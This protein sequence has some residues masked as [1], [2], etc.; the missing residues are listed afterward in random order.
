MLKLLA[1][2]AAGA[3]AGCAAAPSGQAVSGLEGTRWELAVFTSMDDAQPPLRPADPARYTLEFAAEGRVL[4]R[5]DCNSGHS[6]WQATPA[7]GS[8]A[9]RRSGSLGFGPIASTRA[10]C[11][12]GS[13]EPRLAAMLPFVRSFV[14]EQGQL[15]LALLADGGILSWNPI[16]AAPVPR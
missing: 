6:S 15:H 14:I 12:P 3:L 13:L 8:V 2:L 7:P 1:G 9:Q 4:L 11:P 16:P 5:L 10:A